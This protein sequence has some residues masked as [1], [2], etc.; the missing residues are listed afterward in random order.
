M[1]QL[2]LVRHGL[3]EWNANGKFQG[4]SDVPLSE[5]GLAQ[6]KALAQHLAAQGEAVDV[7]YSSPLSRALT[8]AETVFPDSEIVVDERLKE[9]N[10]GMFEG[11]TQAEN[12][13]HEAWAAWI[14]DPFA[15]R[16]PQGESY[17]DL[18]VRAAAWLEDVPKEANSVAFTHSGTIRMLLSHVLGLEHPTWRKRIYLAPTG[19]SR[20]LF[21]GNEAII[22]RVND[23]RHLDGNRLDPFED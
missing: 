2:T 12:E 10:F 9:L 5:E 7:V 11:S 4:H 20:L 3:T 16:T 18:M 15:Q 13:A 14:A 23:T 17:Q 22:E 21:Q 8:T 19:V 1:R 6:A